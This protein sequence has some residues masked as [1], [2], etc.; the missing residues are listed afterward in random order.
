MPRSTLRLRSLAA[1]ELPQVA[2][3]GGQCTFEQ[4]AII[5]GMQGALLERLG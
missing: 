3:Y 1:I 2:H 4:R 5:Q